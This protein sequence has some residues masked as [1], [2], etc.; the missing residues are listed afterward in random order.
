MTPYLLAMIEVLRPQPAQ[1][2]LWRIQFLTVIFAVAHAVFSQR[3]AWFRVPL[4]WIG[5]AAALGLIMGIFLAISVRKRRSWVSWGIPGFILAWG[6]IA[7]ARGYWFKNPAEAFFGLALLAT[8]W[9][10]RSRFKAL[11]SEPYFSP[12]MRWFEGAPR[13]MPGATGWIGLGESKASLKV[14]LVGESGAFVLASTAADQ[15]VLKRQILVAKGTCDL[16]VGFRGAS[17][18]VKVIPVTALSGGRGVGVRVV[19]ATPAMQAQWQ[20]LVADVQEVFHDESH[21]SI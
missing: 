18:L 16:E 3:V 17:A 15:E 4:V 8:S 21:A 10:Y 20:K 19:D 12:P 14:S 2:W 5:A 6:W 9:I 1:K 11:F 7:M 13:A